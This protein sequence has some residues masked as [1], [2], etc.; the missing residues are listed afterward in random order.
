MK[1]NLIKVT[2]ILSMLLLTLIPLS[3]NAATSGTCGDNLTWKLD[4]NGKLTISGTGEMYSFD[5]DD[6]EWYDSKASIKEIVLNKG[7]TSVG[8]Y[9]FSNCKNLTKLSMPE[10]ITEIGKAAFM[11]CDKL[12]N[13][14]MPSTVTAIYSSAFSYCYSLT[15]ITF[16]NSLSFMGEG[17][18]RGCWFSEISIPD[19]TTIVYTDELKIR[20]SVAHILY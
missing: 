15:N 5:D 6:P 1:K 3:V 10:G 20:L 17:A 11:S 4:T 13:F 2:I 18:F 19:S 16:P 7:V 12:G 9:A 14:V 8:E